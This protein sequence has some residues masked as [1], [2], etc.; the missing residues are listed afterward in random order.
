MCGLITQRL[1]PKELQLALQLFAEPDW[2][3]RFAIRPTQPALAVRATSEGWRADSMRWQLVPPWKVELNTS[4]ATWNAVGET[5]AQKPTFRSAF[6]GKRCLIPAE[7]YEWE[8][9]PVHRGKVYRQPWRIHHQTEPMLMLAGLW[10][11]WTSPENETIESCTIITTTPNSFIAELHDRMPVILSPSE[12][13]LWL[14][15]R[16]RAEQLQELLR[17]CPDEWLAR[18]RVSPEALRGPDSPACI[19]PIENPPDLGPRQKTLF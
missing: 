11:S 18:Y 8:K 19:D 1:S 5:I 10:E 4:D 3:P 6:A 14:D 12:W 16:T 9:I 15:P 7:F 2:T 13:S 17:P